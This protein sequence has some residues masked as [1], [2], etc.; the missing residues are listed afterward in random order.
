MARG[1]SCLDQFGPTDAAG[2][3]FS[4]EKVSRAFEKRETSSI[5]RASAQCPVK[6]KISETRQVLLAIKQK[7]KQETRTRRMEAG[8]SGAEP[9]L[10]G[11]PFAPAV[12]DVLLPGRAGRRISP[13]TRCDGT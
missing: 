6:V 10:A 2:G 3:G 5:F 8:A 12:S 7:R 4:A 1:A 11:A 13:R 9:T